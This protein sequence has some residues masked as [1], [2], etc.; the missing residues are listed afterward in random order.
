MPTHERSCG[1]YSNRL[2]D[3]AVGQFDSKVGR[4]GRCEARA[5]AM[6]LDTHAGL[7][8]EV[9]GRLQKATE[10]ASCGRRWSDNMAPSHQSPRGP[11]PRL[12][13]DNL[14]R[15][16]FP[17]ARMKESRTD[18]PFSC[19]HAGTFKEEEPWGQAG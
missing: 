6:T 2:L 7:F 14:C 4:C 5:D 17:H 1:G 10:R 18:M 3:L 9:A 8:D 19:L 12:V 15:H 11:G 16:G 13:E